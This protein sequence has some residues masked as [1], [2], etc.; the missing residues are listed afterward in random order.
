[1]SLKPKD[2]PGTLLE[3]RRQLAEAEYRQCYFSTHDLQ[4]AENAYR[5][6]VGDLDEKV[7]ERLEQAC[8]ALRKTE[9]QAMESRTKALA[10]NEQKEIDLLHLHLRRLLLVDAVAESGIPSN[11]AMSDLKDADGETLTNAMNAF[12]KLQE[13][14]RSLL[15][16]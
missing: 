1:M 10:D 12:Q 7:P 14:R 9:L 13:M 5:L 15:S 8:I 11:P 4:K 3:S 16:G 6:A 2:N